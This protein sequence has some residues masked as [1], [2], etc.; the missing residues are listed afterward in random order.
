MNKQTLRA[1]DVPFFTGA[2]VPVAEVM[3][4]LLSDCY[5]TRKEAA[6]YLR[7]SA[8]RLDHCK[9]LP[10]YGLPGDKG[11]GRVLFKRSELEHL[12]VRVYP[13][14]NEESDKTLPDVSTDRRPEL[15]RI[16]NDFRAKFLSKGKKK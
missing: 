10:R 12:L 5:L 9:E 1:T 14:E 2:V 4:Y 13:I 16:A 7:I 15:D 6:N 11:R 3:N 8:R